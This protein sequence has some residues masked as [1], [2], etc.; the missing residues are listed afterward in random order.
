MKIGYYLQSDFSRAM[1]RQVKIAEK[2]TQKSTEKRW[3]KRA[4]NMRS[5]MKRR[6]EEPRSEGLPILSVYAIFT[7]LKM[8]V[9][10]L[11]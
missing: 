6:A 7:N 9:L 10:W 5:E 1:S 2:C 8:P 11:K 3:Q 4:W